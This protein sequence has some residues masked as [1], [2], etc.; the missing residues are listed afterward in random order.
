MSERVPAGLDEFLAEAG[1]AGATAEPLPWDASFRRYFRMRNGTRTAMLMDAP[2]PNEDQRPFLQV[3]QWL[4]AQGLRAP[5][6]YAERAERGLVL[7]FFFSSRRRHTRWTGDWSSDV[8]SSD[9]SDQRI[10]LLAQADLGQKLPR[11]HVYRV[12]IDDAEA[13]GRMGQEDVLGD[14]QQRNQCQLLVEIGRASC[15]ERV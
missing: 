3:G 10:R 12:A 14:R 8:C 11:A 1:W 13:G 5:A 9:L 4:R 6:I 15:R 7:I 2:P